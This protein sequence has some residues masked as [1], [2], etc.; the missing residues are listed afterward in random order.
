MSDAVHFLLGQRKLISGNIEWSLPPDQEVGAIGFLAPIEIEGVTRA[1]FALRGNAYAHI[2]DQAVTLQLEVGDVSSRTRQPLVR[3]DWRP[4]SLAHK[5]PDK[6][7]ILGTHVHPFALNW[8]HREKR[9]RSGNLP[10]AIEISDLHD[11]AA[12][13]QFSKNLFE[14][15]NIDKIPVPPWSRQLL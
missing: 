5:N 15:N 1:A 8:L 11:F 7:Q 3:L 13:L 6:T 14:I 10:W 2:P 4:R 12:V 9:M